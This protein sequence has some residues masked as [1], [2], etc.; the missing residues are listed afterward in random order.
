VSLLRSV[1]LPTDGKPTS[2]TRASPDF[3]VS[4]DSVLG[5]FDLSE[6]ISVDLRR[7]RRAKVELDNVGQYL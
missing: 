5:P 4:K 2:A 3:L 7:A 1:D 6:S